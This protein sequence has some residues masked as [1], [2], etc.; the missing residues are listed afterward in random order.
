MYKVNFAHK[1]NLSK[2][3]PLYVPGDDRYGLTTG[4]A[5]L[6]EGKTGEMELSVP[7]SNSNRREVVCLTDDIILYRDNVEIFRGRV[8]TTQ[9]DFYLT[10]RLTIEGDMAYLYDTLYPPFTYKGTPKALLQQIIANHN[11][12]VPAWKQFT[13]GTVTVKDNNNYIARE[14]SSYE[15][16]LDVLTSRFIDDD[17]GGFF[18]T[19]YS[20][21]KRYLDYLANYDTK[22]SQTIKFGSN[23]ID[24]AEEIEYGELITAILPLGKMPER[25]NAKSTD[26]EQ[27]DADRINV[28]SVNGGD[29]YIRNKELIDRYG[30]IA[31][32]VTW[33]DIEKPAN[34]KT[35]GDAYLKEHGVSIQRFTINCFDLAHLYPDEYKH[36]N[37]GDTAHLESAPHGVDQQIEL[38]KINLNLLAPEQDTFEFDDEKL[39]KSK[40]FS[41]GGSFVS[42]TMG[43][44]NAVTTQI[45]NAVKQVNNTVSTTVANNFADI[46]GSE[47]VADIIANGISDDVIKLIEGKL[48]DYDPLSSGEVEDLVDGKLAAA[49]TEITEE[50]GIAIDTLHTQIQE[51]LVEFEEKILEETREIVAEEINDLR[52][53]LSE[54]VDTK[55]LKAQE[56][57]VG[58]LEATYIKTDYSNIGVANIGEFFAKSG[59]LE[60]IVTEN[61]TITG[62]L[63]G[64]TIKGDLIEGNTIK[65]DKLVIKGS[66]GLYYKLNTDGETIESEQTDENSL[67]GSHIRA[68][69]ITASKI[70]VSDL[71]AFNATIAG[72]QMENGA[73][74]TFGKD[75]V[76][77]P[78]PGIY[79]DSKG[80]FNTGDDTNYIV[81]WYDTEN[82]K[83]RVR[84]SADEVVV[85][86]KNLLQAVTG[87]EERV[88]EATELI[89]DMQERMDSGEFKGE[90][91]AV[92]RIDSSRGTVFKN[93]AVSTI[94]TVAIYYGPER[95]TTLS[96][97]KTAFGNTAHLTWYWQRLDEDR[98]GIISAN[99]E[100]LSD[101][102]FTLTLSPDQVD[103]K[104]T[105][106]CELEID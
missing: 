100:M 11:K 85:G 68:K 71:V 39:N 28:S 22:A 61:G 42:S 75:N 27:T 78:M 52:E 12:Y 43:V 92:L 56:A 74:H 3:Y 64:V 60:D 16:T 7:Y 72:L 49:R 106:R 37:L 90:D 76:D 19:R 18:R 88:A 14:N 93:N 79:F 38:T 31:E 4:K 30:F 17:I 48:V 83:W 44:N 46:I 69:T 62:E 2:E 10:G 102:G 20:G 99:D 21:G 13:L 58:T 101:G 1:E 105:F 55:V 15:K 53:D 94:L 34:L 59:I 63:V 104:V 57:Y 82:E 96:G 36:F 84:I 91:A 41:N 73:I 47:G 66:D 9:Q 89:D 51:E 26:P 5:T 33:D 6:E 32:T 25:K 35:K 81:S 45:N 80:Q 65:A 8:V 77:N 97:L 98:Y 70:A 23:I 29:I 50:I 103:T 24:L 67:D 54:E 86:K 40:G 95:I 87:A